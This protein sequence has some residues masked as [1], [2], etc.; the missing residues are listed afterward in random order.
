MSFNTSIWS[1]YLLFFTLQKFSTI[2][3]MDNGEFKRLVCSPKNLKLKEGNKVHFE[4]VN[5]ELQPFEKETL[6]CSRRI[7][8]AVKIIEH[9]SNWT[10]DETKRVS[11]SI[12][13]QDSQCTEVRFASFLSGGFITAIV[14][15]PPERK[16]AKR[17]SVQSC[18]HHHVVL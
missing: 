10:L 14:G 12:H 9:H 7:D 16:L 3:K 6:L 13:A 15:N 4:F 17:T 18:N 8:R 11:F 1:K 5:K 2:S